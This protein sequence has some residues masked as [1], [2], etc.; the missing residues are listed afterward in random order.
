ME[1]K[2]DSDELDAQGLGP[3]GVKGFGV[4]WFAFAVGEQQGQNTPVSAIV[5]GGSDAEAV[6]EPVVIVEGR[7]DPSVGRHKVKE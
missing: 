2:G 1:E 5:G 7:D 6:V 3:F 4:E